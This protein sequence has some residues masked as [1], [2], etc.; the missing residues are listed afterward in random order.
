MASILVVEDNEM[1]LEIMSRRLKKLGHEVLF[2]LDGAEAVEKMK[3]E[4][5]DLV[6][7]DMSLPVMDGWEATRRIKAEPETTSIPIIGLS[8]HAM[9]GDREKAL[10]AGCD[11]Y[12]TKPVNMPRLQAKIEAMLKG[13]SIKQDV[14]AKPG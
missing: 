9:S 4:A 14:G 3:Q 5:P 7:M 2:A 1:N 8:A 11:D 13:T 12:D 6:L 10:E